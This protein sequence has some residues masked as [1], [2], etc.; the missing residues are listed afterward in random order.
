MVS[1][2]VIQDYEKL[3]WTKRMREFIEIHNS[4]EYYSRNRCIQ[5]TLYEIR[6]GLNVKTNS[7]N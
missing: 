5:K 1:T 2:S 4:Q 7:I 3:S 6:K